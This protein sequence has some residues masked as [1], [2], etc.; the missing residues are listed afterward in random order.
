MS[1]TTTP[2]VPLHRRLLWQRGQLLAL[3]VLCLL[4]AAALAY[5]NSRRPL[6]L[7]ETIP[8]DGR[9]IA[10]ADEKINPNTA[11]AASLDRL[12]GI[13]PTRAAAIVA[14]R[15]QAG[16]NAFHTAEDLTKIKG[17]GKATVEHLAPYLSLP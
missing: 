1:E 2:I 13:G 7:G 14:Y 16:P 15:N 10:L 12:P 5:E 11:S 3:I 17:I 9:K 4:S 8:V 6:L